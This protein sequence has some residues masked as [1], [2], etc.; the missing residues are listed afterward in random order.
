MTVS[1]A[2]YLAR[3]IPGAAAVSGN[4]E[5]ALPPQQQQRQRQE[6]E[7]QLQSGD[8][9]AL[10]GACTQKRKVMTRCFSTSLPAPPYPLHPFLNSLMKALPASEVAAAELVYSPLVTR[11]A[12][13]VQRGRPLLPRL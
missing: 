4:N 9:S 2:T 13:R 5:A 10:S 8:D 3:R 6:E 12:A 11:R 7:V 1:Q